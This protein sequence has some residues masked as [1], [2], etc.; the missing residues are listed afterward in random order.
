VIVVSGRLEVERRVLAVQEQRVARRSPVV[1]V[2]HGDGVEHL[3]R[4]PLGEQHGDEADQ[5]E[6]LPKRS[7]HRRH[8]EVRD[9]E[10]PLHEWPP[11]GDAAVDREV[12]LDGIGGGQ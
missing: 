3:T 11:P 6:E 5:R 10:E 12:E 2:G 1:P 8:R 4:D 9:G 7:E